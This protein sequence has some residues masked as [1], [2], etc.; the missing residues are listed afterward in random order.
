MAFAVGDFEL[1]SFRRDLARRTADAVQALLRRI[2]SEHL[3]GFALV[4]SGEAWFTWVRAS[5]NTE[6]GLA[7]RAVEVR[8]GRAP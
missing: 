2:G 4:T 8:P 5:A 6:E 7:R 1:G 3:Y